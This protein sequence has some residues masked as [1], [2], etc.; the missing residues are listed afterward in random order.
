MTPSS[1]PRRAAQYLRMSTEHQRY[2][3]EHQEAAIAAYAADRGYTVVRS[4]ADAGISGLDLRKRK[5]LQQLL[6]DV[7]G[8]DAGFEVILTLDISRWGRFQDLDESAHYEFVCRQAGVGVEYCAEPFENDGA[9]VSSLLKHMKRIMAAEY[10]REL[11]SKIRRAKRLTAAK[12]YWQCAEPGFGL[13]R[14]LVDEQRRPV[15]ILEAHERKATSA[16]KTVLAPGPPGEVET[17]RR[18]YSLFVVGGLKRTAIARLLNREGVATNTGRP[19]DNSKVHRILVSRKYAG[20]YVYGQTSYVLGRR[21]GRTPPDQW[22]TAE[23]AHEPIVERWMSDA[24]I[25]IVAGRQVRLDDASM[26]ECLRGVF[27]KYGRLTSDL[28]DAEEGLPCTEVYRK[29]FGSLVNAYRLAGYDPT[30]RQAWIA[31]V[32]RRGQR[33]YVRRNTGELLTNDDLLARLADLLRR[34]G[35]LSRSLIDDAPELPS[36]TICCDRLGGG[37]A[38]VYAQVGFEPTDWRQVTALNRWR[39]G[40]CRPSSDQNAPTGSDAG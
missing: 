39:A 37:L 15:Q 35:R 10:S 17:V 32:D 33:S 9:P 7:L 27:A 22:I 8:G 16:Y 12:G 26:I 36:A 11:S 1:S 34:H 3:I 13:R 30:H 38:K 25:R 29:R 19:W 21:M 6:A 2:S 5:A 40:R 4:Y 18:I 14:M 23:A 28:I 20:I 31:T 24:A